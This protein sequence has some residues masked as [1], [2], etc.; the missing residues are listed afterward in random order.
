[1]IGIDKQNNNNYTI[2]FKLIVYVLAVFLVLTSNTLPMLLGKWQNIG[3]IMTLLCI[4]CLILIIWFKEELSRKSIETWLSWAILLTFVYMI[5]VL[6]GGN[7]G[8][9]KIILAFA[10][11]VTFPLLIMLLVASY[12]LDIFFK[13]I[14]NVIVIVALM[15]LILWIF[16]PV[17]G[18]LQPNCVIENHWTGAD[19]HVLTPG[20]FHLQYTPQTM[21]MPN[22]M[23]VVRNTSF[24]AEA[25]MFSLVLTIALLIET[26]F[27]R[28]PRRVV[29]CILSITILTTVSTAGIVALV[30]TLFFRFLLTFYGKF[31]RYRVLLVMLC[32]A[33][34]AVAIPLLWWL[35]HNKLGSG[36]G[37]VRIDDLRAGLRAWSN[38]YLLGNGFGAS[39]VVNIYK[40]DFRSNNMGFSNT[41]LDILAKGGVVYFLI[42]FI[43]A[44]GYLRSESIYWKVGF[45]IFIFV[46]IVTIS[47]N[48][49]LTF[50]FFGIGFVS[51]V[52]E[53]H[54]NQ[55]ENVRAITG[56]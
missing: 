29:L 23:V 54:E 56:V 55:S 21:T 35:V 18:L 44:L 43:P 7:L 12:N 2:F 38:S 19:Y 3:L 17:L 33:I 34:L 22:G 13:A 25:P 16:G 50:L 51:L 36:S 28:R 8:G 47:T 40:S 52:G 48:L 9:V 15:S 27:V 45:L 30:F 41:L 6:S 31:N 11:F 37:S 14:V 53:D 10:I 26:F 49:P 46:W 42:Y 4:S 24:F 1:M 32:I 39:D 5:I 20:Y